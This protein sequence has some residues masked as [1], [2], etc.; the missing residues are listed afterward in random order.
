MDCYKLINLGNNDCLLLSCFD[1]LAHIICNYE[2]LTIWPIFLLSNY[3]N[4]FVTILTLFIFLVYSIII[5]YIAYNNEP[6][7]L[8]PSPDTVFLII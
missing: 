6:T 4:H 5:T 7:R 3:F 2:L 1:I 8:L